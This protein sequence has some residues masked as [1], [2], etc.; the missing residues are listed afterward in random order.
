MAM[1]V[2]PLAGALGARITGIDLGGDF[3]AEAF[4][5]IHAAWLD[6]LVLV[7]PGQELSA[8]AQLRFTEKFGEIGMRKRTVARPEGDGVHPGVM[9][10]S[11]I[12]EDGK[13]IGSLPDG[14]MMFHSDGAYSAE[15]FR[16]TLLYAIDVPPVGGDT[17]FANM[18]RAFDTLPGALKRRLADCHGCHEY[19]AG[20]VQK[21]AP[22]GDYSGAYVHPLFIE[23]EE[24]HRTALFVSRLITTRIE[25]MPADESDAV[26]EE[27][28]AHAE[29]PEFVY[30]HV[31][32]K[33]DFVLWDN[34]CSNHARTD[35]P[36]TERRQ[37]RRTTVLGTAPAAARLQA[38]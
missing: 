1:E 38:A 37:M 35:F 31:W 34:R 14:E 9:L 7:F 18:Y 8:D 26:L 6:H 32:A 21:D 29:R 5:A 28:F 24:T 3:G 27:L 4:A 30:R 10:I 16:Y 22:S 12:R 13:P 17:L 2:T 36:E 25:E 19:Y 20:S 11:N 15:P 23:H 33:G